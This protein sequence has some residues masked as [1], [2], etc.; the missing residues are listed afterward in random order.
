MASAD[1]T[2]GAG[3]AGAGEVAGAVVGVLVGVPGGAFGVVGG[4]FGVVGGVFGVAGGVFGVAGGVFGV[5]GGA[6]GGGCVGAEDESVPCAAGADGVPA[7]EVAGLVDA[8]GGACARTGPTA[9]RLTPSKMRETSSPRAI[10]SLSVKRRSIPRYYRHAK[11]CARVG[12]RLLRRVP[13][14]RIR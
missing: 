13:N 14:I 12:P 2:V 10:T 4:V 7:G 5:A 3:V 8:S 9:A 1:G 11:A 6:L